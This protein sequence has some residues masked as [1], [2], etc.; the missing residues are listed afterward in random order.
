[1]ALPALP[2]FGATLHING[3]MLNLDRC[4]SFGLRDDLGASAI[5]VAPCRDERMATRLSVLGVGFG[6]VVTSAILLFLRRRDMFPTRACLAALNAAYLANAALCLVVYGAARGIVWSRSGW[7]VT[8]LIVWPMVLE[9]VWLFIQ[10]FKT[11]PLQI[12]SRVA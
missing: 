5:P 4:G 2:L 11:Q 10:T 3:T 9:L 1:M 12:N 8:L 6:I 7:L